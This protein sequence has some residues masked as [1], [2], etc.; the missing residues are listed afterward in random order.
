MKL[1]QTVMGIA[2]AGLLMFSADSAQASRF[3]FSD[4]PVAYGTARHSTGT[5]QRLGNLWDSESSP[6]RTNLDASDDGVFWSTDGGT[7]WGHDDLLAGDE[8]MFGFQ[9]TRAGFGIHDYDGLKAWVDWNGDTTWSSNETIIDVQWDKGDTQVADD[10]YASYLATH[11]SVIN[12]EAQLTRF[13]ITSPHLISQEMGDLGGLWLRA[14]VACSSSIV[15]AG[16]EMTPFNTINQG[17][18]EDWLVGT[19]TP[20]SGNTP[21]PGSMLLMSSALAGLAAWR[22]RKK[23]SQQG[24]QSL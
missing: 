7:S 21:E 17:E 15:N 13:F 3:E 14:R 8:V 20:P 5:W 1:I 12:P 22:R 11:G 10:V 19:R 24:G 18:T 23:K 6:L 4:A 16:G 9:F 2:C